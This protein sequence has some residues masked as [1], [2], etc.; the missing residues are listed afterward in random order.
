MV[1]IFPGE[2]L[3]RVS[4]AFR[5]RLPIT[6]TIGTE[7]STPLQMYWNIVFLTMFENFNYKLSQQNEVLVLIPNE[8][9]TEMETLR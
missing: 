3:L 2:F 6:S 7:C 9:I 5:T 1:Q 4:H 8:D